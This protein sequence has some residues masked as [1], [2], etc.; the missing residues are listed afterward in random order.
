MRKTQILIADDHAVMRMGLTA[1]FD[2][3]PAFKIIGEASN[4]LEAADKAHTLKPDIIIMDLMMPIMDGVAATRRIQQNTPETKVLLLTTFGTS[5]GIA[6]ALDAG[7]TGAILKSASNE[8]LIAA[9]HAVASG[10]LFIAKD[11]QQ[12]LKNEPPVQPLTERQL[13]ILSF[14]TRG[15][16]NQDIAK[17]LGIR[18]DSVGQNLSTIF[19]KLG[20][21]NRAEATSIALRKHLL[22]I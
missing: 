10:K 16:T 14:V 17:A 22:K 13:E 5:D 12:L 9:V 19:A 4:G 2:T 11:V 21:A 3:V 1:L 7:A 15:L 8:E 18:V 6:Q 20:A